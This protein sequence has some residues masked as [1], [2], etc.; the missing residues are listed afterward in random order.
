MCNSLT[1]MEASCAQF[2]NQLWGVK[3]LRRGSGESNHSIA[4]V[5]TCCTTMDIVS[6]V[7]LCLELIEIP[8]QLWVF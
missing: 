1:H 5:K 4:Q 3:G 8:S 2:S 7:K 6:E